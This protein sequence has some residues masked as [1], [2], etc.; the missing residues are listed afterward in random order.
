MISG[1][2]NQ[3]VITHSTLVHVFFNHFQMFCLQGT[4]MVFLDL[5]Q[6][7]HLRNVELKYF[8]VYLML[9]KPFIDHKLPRQQ[10]QDQYKL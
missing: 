4:L 1:H 5:N 6:I 9:G 8:L 3:Y 7:F 2:I 10:T